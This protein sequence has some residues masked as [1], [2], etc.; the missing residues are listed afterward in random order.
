MLLTAGY[1]VFLNNRARELRSLVCQSQKNSSTTKAKH[2]LESLRISEQISNAPTGFELHFCRNSLRVDT[3][4]RIRIFS[5]G[6]NIDILVCPSSIISSTTK[7]K[8]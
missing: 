1:L 3:G 8:W 6:R 7:Q 5:K 4:V 2:Y